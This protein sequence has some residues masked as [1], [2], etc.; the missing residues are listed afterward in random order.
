[1]EKPFFLAN[2]LLGEKKKFYS[3]SYL[4]KKV[5]LSNLLSRNFFWFF[6]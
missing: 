1:M 5:L 4:V 3:V 2:F 6:R